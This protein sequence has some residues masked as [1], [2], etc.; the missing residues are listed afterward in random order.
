VCIM[1]TF[2]QTLDEWG[3]QLH[4]VNRIQGCSY[5]SGDFAT[6]SLPNS[7]VGRFN[8]GVFALNIGV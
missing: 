3:I 4:V 8:L 7:G 6:C 2:C 5:S 1:V